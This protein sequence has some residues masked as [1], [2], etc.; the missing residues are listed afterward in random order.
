MKKD[1]Q[2]KILAF[3][4]AR[5]RMP[6]ITEVMKLCGF[7]SRSSAF[8]LTQKLVKDGVVEKD[9]QGKVV[10]SPGMHTLRVLGNIRA[11]FAA[12]AEEELADT[13]TVGEYLIRHKESSYLL[14]VEGDSMK[15]AGILEGDM[16]IFERRT[17]AKPGDIVVALTEDGYT[18][19]FLRK[20][21]STALRAGKYYLEAANDEYSDMF[22]VEGQIIGVVTSTFRTY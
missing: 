20:N 7:S 18:L 9:S 14:K 5:R 15:G 16:V 10:P 6:N 2:K 19:K 13:I 3:Y 21:P 1:Y 12:P 4:R 17:D 11:G 22:P 8:Y